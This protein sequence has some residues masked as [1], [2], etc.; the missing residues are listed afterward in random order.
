MVESKDKGVIAT[1]NK[2]NQD[3]VGA[4][5]I[6]AD[7]SAVSL[8]TRASFVSAPASAQPPPS[9]TVIALGPGLSLLSQLA[10]GSGP[11]PVPSGRKFPLQ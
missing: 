10:P 11:I 7:L 8:R 5:D 9:M 1:K 4:R 2:K 3:S 6:V